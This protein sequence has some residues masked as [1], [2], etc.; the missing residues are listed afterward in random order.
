MIYLD[1][2]S[3]GALP[4][5]TPDRIA[6]AV[7]HEWGERLIRSWNE[8][9][10]WSASRRVA[11]LLAPLLGASADEIAVADSTS[12]NLFKLLVAALAHAAGQAGG[13]RGAGRVPHGCLHCP[14]GY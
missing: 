13:G 1:G 12:V 8:A 3:L 4:R 5:S 9:G 2:N 14:F 11:D 7:R 6:R 10:W